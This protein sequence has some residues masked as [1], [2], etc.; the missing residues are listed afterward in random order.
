MRLC[1]VVFYEDYP[2]RLFEMVAEDFYFVN[3]HINIDIS[4]MKR[5]ENGMEG[6]S[7]KNSS[8][9]DGRGRSFYLCNER[10]HSVA[11]SL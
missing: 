3:L 11:L 2:L 7:R 1:K 8:E 5:G 10:F 4:N 9:P 6:G